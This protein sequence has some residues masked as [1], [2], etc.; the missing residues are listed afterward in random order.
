MKD[1]LKQRSVL[2]SLSA[3]VLGALFHFASPEGTVYSLGVAL[4]LLG[5]FSFV[6]LGALY[7]FKK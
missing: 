5:L 3:V 7:L 6:G 4:V 1:F 2:V